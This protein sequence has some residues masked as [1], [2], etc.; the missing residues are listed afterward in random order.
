MTK[1]DF[2]NLKIISEKLGQWVDINQ[3]EPDDFIRRTEYPHVTEVKKDVIYYEN[4][5]SPDNPVNRTLLR[6]N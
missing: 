1:Y 3:Y 4:I 5:K 2:D 6:K